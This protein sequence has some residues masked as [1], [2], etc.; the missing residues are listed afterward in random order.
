MIRPG[1]N[2]A[3]KIPAAEYE[4]TVAFYREVLELRELGQASDGSIGFDLDG[5]DLWL[6]RVEA[7]TQAEVWLELVTDDLEAAAKHFADHE[8]SRC[9]EVEELPEGFRGFWIK[10]PAG[11][12]HLVSERKGE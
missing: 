2:I 1:R 8:V 4:S 11:L 5:K 3:L 9:D 6:D 7:I 10:N 12:V